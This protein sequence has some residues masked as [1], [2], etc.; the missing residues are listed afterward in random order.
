[1]SEDTVTGHPLA[2]AW[3]RV[4]HDAAELDPAVFTGQY[5]RD[6]SGSV[7][8]DGIPV[9][10]LARR[11]G[12][13]AY[14]VSER[15]FRS[16][17]RRVREAFDA[18][19]EPLGV[20]VAV[21]YASKALLC[22]SVARWAVAEGLG[23]D[24]ASGGELAVALAAGVPG[25]RI[26]LHGNNKSA[27]ELSAALDAGVGRI[28][29]DSLPEVELLA[30]LARQRGTRAPVM[31]RVTPGVHAS[32]HEFIAT[33]H[34]DQKFGLSLHAAAD[35]EDSPALQAVAAC[36]AQDD[37]LELRGLHCHI[38]SQIFAAEG[39]AQAAERVLALRE[40][41][42]GRWG[43]ALPEIDLG[44]GHGVAYTAADSA[45]EI[46]DIAG[47]LASLLA[48]ALET[49]Q[50]P[51][52]HLSFEPGRYI[53]GPSG[54]TVYTV[55]TV[56]TV[57]VSPGVQRRYVSVDGGMSDN[58]RPVLYDADYTAVLAN[59]VS[60]E[61][62]VL[63]RVVGKHCESGDVVVKDVYLP[64]DVHRGDL[65]VVPVTGAYCWSLSSNY[66]W[67]PRPGIVAVGED[68]VPREIVRRE[69]VA[70]LLARDPGAGADTTS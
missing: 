31:L 6:A 53:A 37:A 25:G 60:P 16:R 18:A 29:V 48:K 55:G 23:I 40:T 44:G 3:L 21:Y 20:Q 45:R 11:H 30:T 32:T 24:T 66:N 5:A 7:T 2:P 59:R 19:L 54:C 64:G 43:L 46:T 63:S 28:V 27:E 58:A 1:M 33:A 35:G 9:T 56:K 50:L 47:D 8:V 4:P 49:S 26:A 67:L 61:A 14:V 68:G 65:L 52:P 15:T 38:G 70:D 17:A 57:T 10:E 39:F 12:S 69:S 51:A 36:L 22:T 42:A 34:E 41:V 62:P 13:P